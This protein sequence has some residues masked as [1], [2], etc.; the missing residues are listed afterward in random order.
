MFWRRRT[1]LRRS[2]TVRTRQSVR[3]FRDLLSSAE[4]ISCGF[5]LQEN[6]SASVL[7]AGPSV[8]SARGRLGLSLLYPASQRQSSLSILHSEWLESNSTFMVMFSTPNCS[9]RISHKSD[10]T[11]SFCFLKSRQTDRCYHTAHSIWLST[12]QNPKAMQR[13]G[14]VRIEMQKLLLHMLCHGLKTC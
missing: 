1:H 13:V 12:L 14:E 10:T 2:L 5:L 8:C 6:T 3:L 9:Q 11:S 4:S 7:Y